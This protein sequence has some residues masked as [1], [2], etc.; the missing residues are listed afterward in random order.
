MKKVVVVGKLN[1]QETIVQE[2]FVVDG[3]EIPSGENFVVKSL[4]DSPSVSWQET[5]IEKMKT[6]Y[7]DAKKY[8][9]REMNSL[10]EN[11]KKA[12]AVFDGCTEIVR[13]ANPAMFDSVSKLIGGDYKFALISDYSG[14]SIVP[15][16]DFVIDR[17]GWDINLKLISIFGKSNGD[18]SW[19][20]NRYRDYSGS[21]QDFQFFETR[22]SALQKAEDI[23]NSKDY[24][25]SKVKFLR[26]NG[27]RVDKVKLE[28]MVS[29]EIDSLA[30]EI[31]ANK[32]RS[33]VLLQSIA[34]KTKEL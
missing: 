24:T 4:H 21:W 23:I 14:V 8:Y 17:D 33:D 32:K 22:D 11:Q 13:K 15:I 3:N 28:R 9:E 25:R 6:R 20:V 31:D 29:D 12:R 5:E 19:M 34:D 10:S 27:L 30:S 16:L 1:N 2:V 26:D 7:E 18:F